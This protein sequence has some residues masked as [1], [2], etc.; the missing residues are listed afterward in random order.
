MTTKPG[1]SLIIGPIKS[2]VAIVISSIQ[3]NF[4]AVHPENFLVQE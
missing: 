1:I 3:R 4:M 2:P